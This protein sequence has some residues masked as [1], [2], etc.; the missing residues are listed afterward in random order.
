[1]KSF[2]D[3][4]FT[5]LSHPSPMHYELIHN[6]EQPQNFLLEKSYSVKC[7][8]ILFVEIQISAPN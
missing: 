3:F 6:Y 1:M 5:E 8:K 2:K 7:H 4:H